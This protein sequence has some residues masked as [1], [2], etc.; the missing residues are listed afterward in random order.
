MP[1]LMVRGFTARVKPGRRIQGQKR[2][3]IGTLLLSDPRFPNVGKIARVGRAA[4]G[5]MLTGLVQAEQAVDRK[6][7]FG[8][9]LVLLAIVFPP[10]NRAQREGAGRIQRLVSAAGAAKTSLQRVHT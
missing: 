10:A 5:K 9:I 4:V 2:T 3:V 7:D 8:G 6:A 1:R